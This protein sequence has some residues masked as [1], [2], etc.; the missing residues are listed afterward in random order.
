M[1][2][3]EKFFELSQHGTSVRQEVT[4]GL[5]TF[6]AMALGGDIAI[7]EVRDPQLEISLVVADPDLTTPIGIAVDRQNRIFVVESHT[8]ERKPDYPGPKQDR[9]KIILESSA[10]EKEAPSGVLDCAKAHLRASYRGQLLVR[11]SC[12]R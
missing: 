6:A 9:I 3:L 7:P 8:H 11:G 2:A 4:A 1:L 10:G 5:T 12:F